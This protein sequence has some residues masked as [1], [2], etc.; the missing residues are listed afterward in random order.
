MNTQP[1]F[2]Q[3]IIFDLDG[4]LLNTLADIA[5]SVNRTLAEY[6]F[7][8]HAIDAYKYFIGNGW[9]MLVTR[10]M[11]ETHRSKELIAE[12]VTKS[13]KIYRDNW[14]RQTRLY[15]G[16]PELLDKLAADSSVPCPPTIL[17]TAKGLELDSQGLETRY[18]LISVMHKP[19]SP[20][21][22]CDLIHNHVGTPLEPTPD[23]EAIGND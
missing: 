8:S 10:A 11:P 7:P 13:R 2:Y 23:A 6:Q 1:D 18:N 19:F 3:A 20:R 15:E 4:T 9:K 17:C 21:K 14:N 22:L 12:C 5:E 16:I